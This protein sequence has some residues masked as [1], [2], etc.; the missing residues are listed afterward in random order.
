MTPVYKEYKVNN[1][2][3]ATTTAHNEVFYWVTT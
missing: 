2:T 1:G 3:G